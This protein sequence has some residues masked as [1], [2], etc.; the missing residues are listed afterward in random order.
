MPKTDGSR[1]GQRLLALRD[2]LLSAPGRKWRTKEIA[3]KL[4]VSVDTAFRYLSGLSRTGRVPLISTGETANFQWELDPEI[5]M[6]LPA[7]HLSYAQ[8]AALFA[9]ARLLSQQH[10]ERNDAVRTASLS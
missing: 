9:A 6:P 7:L 8:G 2:M 4:G 10:D 5:R 1:Q 3:D